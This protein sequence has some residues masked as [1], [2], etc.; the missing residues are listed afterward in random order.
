MVD[1]EKKFAALKEAEARNWVEELKPA[2]PRLKKIVKVSSLPKSFVT[3]K[4]STQHPLL[5]VK[6]AYVL[7]CP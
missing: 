3:K 6:Y 7:L 4:R 5:V 2:A 1:V